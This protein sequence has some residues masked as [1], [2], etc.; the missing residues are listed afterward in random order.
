MNE[1]IKDL[2]V[3]DTVIVTRRFYEAIVKVEKITP[4]GNI[5]AGKSMFLPNGTE[6]GGDIW[7]KAYLRKATPEY[8][9]RII[10][11]NTIKKAITLMRETSNIT[12]EQAKT[13]IDLL[14]CSNNKR[15]DS[16]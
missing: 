10:Q 1:W 9:E 13:I 7:N 14:G 2:K 11:N 5:K 8:I 6:R 12:Y 3:G 15:S 16:E 4:A